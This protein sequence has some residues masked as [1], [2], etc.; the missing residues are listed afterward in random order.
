MA[1]AAR[2]KLPSAG[3]RPAASG[4]AHGSP[5]GLRLQD[6]AQAGDAGYG[7]FVRTNSEA[8]AAR[9]RPPLTKRLSPRHWTALDYV[10]GVVFGLILFA[11]I[12]HGPVE[13]IESPYGWVTYRPLVLT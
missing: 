11:S 5:R 10:V 12:R 6:D 7:S 9:Q 8:P 1:S 2:V 4:G 13:T 3:R